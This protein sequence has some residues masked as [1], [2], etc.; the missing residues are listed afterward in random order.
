[1]VTKKAILKLLKKE[2]IPAVL[3][4]GLAMRIYNSPRVTHDM[5]LAIK[6]IDVDKVIIFMYKHGF[7]LVM[8]AGDETVRLC[9]TGGEASEWVT[10]ERPGSMSFFSFPDPVSSQEMP[11]S[12]VDINS[13][14][15]FLYDISIPFS[16]LYKSAQ[17]IELDAVTISVASAEDLLYLKERRSEKSPSDYADI[18][19]LRNLLVKNRPHQKP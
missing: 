13:E 2:S 7:Y 12:S 10:S 6:T 19:F 9:Q 16:R 17:A 8:S 18:E 11:V 1:M 14:V 5:D 15:D 4:G 3:I